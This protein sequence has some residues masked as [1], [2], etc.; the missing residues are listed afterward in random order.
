MHEK[1]PD[2]RSGQRRQNG[3]PSAP[4]SAHPALQLQRAVGNRAT[5]RI[6]QRRW[7]YSEKGI[8]MWQNQ[9]NGN[10]WEHLP[11]LLVE[12]GINGPKTRTAARLHKWRLGKK[13]DEVPEPRVIDTQAG[14]L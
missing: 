11:E 7:E 6:L 4:I 1:L 14:G 2:Q 9:L 5:S 12:D 10:E 3:T 8:K 13:I